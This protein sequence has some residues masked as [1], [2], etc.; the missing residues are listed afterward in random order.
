[1]GKSQAAFHAA[2][3]CFLLL[4]LLLGGILDPALARD[5]LTGSE[6]VRAERCTGDYACDEDGSWQTTYVCPQHRP[7]VADATAGTREQPTVTA[8]RVVLGGTATKQAGSER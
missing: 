6:A 3:G 5:Q 4:F 8:G 7:A 1:M 2:L